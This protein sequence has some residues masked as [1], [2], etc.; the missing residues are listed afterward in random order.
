MDDPKCDTCGA[1]ITT[2]LMALFCPRKEQCEFYPD[3]EQGR[4]FLRELQP[5]CTCWNPSG[6]L[7]DG[8]HTSNCSLHRAHPNG[9]AR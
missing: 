3:D 5:V 4:Q 6:M 8:A 1:E 2:G 7:P 9:G